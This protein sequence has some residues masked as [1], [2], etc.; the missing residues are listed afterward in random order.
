[1]TLTRQLLLWAVLLGGVLAVFDWTPA[2]LAVQDYFYNSVK[3]QWLVEKHDPIPRWVFYHGPKVLL[4]AFGVICVLGLLLSF[5]RGR[6]RRLRRPCLLMLLSL[7]IIPL[8]ISAGK[9][10][11]N[12]YTPRQIVRYGG[13]KPYVKTLE[14]YPV[15]FK[16]GKPGKGFPAGHASGGFALMMLYFAC[17]GKSWRI[18]GLA[19]GLT[20]GWAMGAYQMLI[21]QHYLSHTLVTMI[22][23]WIV[24]L[25]CRAGV[26][27]CE[28]VAGIWWPNP[29]KNK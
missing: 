7:A 27:A 25:L 6:H 28:G 14:H 20:A 13:D 3:H 21:G 11:S 16:A 15:G 8:T 12:V 10:I 2:D 23:A 22:L 1:M 4:V 19:L 9:Q 17:Q 29:V 5:C 18:A 26:S 24:I